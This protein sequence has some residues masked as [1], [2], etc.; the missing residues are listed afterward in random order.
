MKKTVILSMLLMTASIVSFAQNV[1]GNCYRGFIDAGYTIGVGDY[2]MGRFE[3]NTSHGY[4]I[5]PFIYLGAGLGLHF[6][7]SYETG[8]MDIPLDIRESKVDIPV[9]ANARCNFLKGKYS[10][11]I[12]IKGGTYVNNNGGLYINASA[13]C[14]FA[15]GSKQAINLSIGYTT[16]KLE[17]ETFDRFISSS[18]MDYTRDATTYNAE[19]VSIK[20][21]Y[22]F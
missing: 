12:D 18:S 11:F 17:F 21:G 4:Q 8:G 7:P 16:Q 13:G 14:R 19:G 3:V 10:P 6:F 22:E 9:F 15:I 2:D 20:L 5:N 1:S